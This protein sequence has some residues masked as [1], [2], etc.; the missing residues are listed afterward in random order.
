VFVAYGSM[1]HCCLISF[2][3][4]LKKKRK[5]VACT[6]QG[7]GSSDAWK[8]KLSSNAYVRKVFFFQILLMDWLYNIQQKTTFVL[9]LF[10]YKGI[11]NVYYPPRQQGLAL[12]LWACLIK[13]QF[14]HQLLSPMSWA[15]TASGGEIQWKRYYMFYICYDL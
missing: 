6:F 10:F 4:I 11:S 15:S 12:C 13:N 7:V 5:Y 3:E 1:Q 9:F 14:N 2:N 8:E